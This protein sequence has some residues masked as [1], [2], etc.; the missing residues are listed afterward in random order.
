MT[1]VQLFQL[2]NLDT[3]YAQLGLQLVHN[4]DNL[5][6]LKF[7]TPVDFEVESYLSCLL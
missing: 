3:T 1:F 5:I 4:S 2:Q 6:E 7:V